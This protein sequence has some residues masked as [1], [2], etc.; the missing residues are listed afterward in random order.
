MDSL[1]IHGVINQTLDSVSRRKSIERECKLLSE[2]LM[3]SQ[4]YQ[5]ASLVNTQLHIYLILAPSGIRCWSTSNQN[6][7]PSTRPLEFYYEQGGGRMA[8]PCICRE[9]EESSFVPIKRVGIFANAAQL[10]FGSGDSHKSRPWFE[11]EMHK[12]PTVSSGIG[13]AGICWDPFSRTRQT[14]P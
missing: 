11:D 12:V 8:I 3:V 4:F 9:L 6:G 10:D 1:S 7:A 14:Q 5:F 2:K 13:L